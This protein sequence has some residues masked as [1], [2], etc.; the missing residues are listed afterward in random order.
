MS[1][2]FDF[3]DT[4]KMSVISIRTDED[5]ASEV[6]KI[7]KKHEV[8]MPQVAERLLRVGLEEYHKQIESSDSGAAD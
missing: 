4:R 3:K 7:A 5:L 2:R 6:F 1:N 8:N